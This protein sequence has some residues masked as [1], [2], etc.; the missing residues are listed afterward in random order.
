MSEE[1]GRQHDLGVWERLKQSWREADDL[2]VESW[3]EEMDAQ[4][5]RKEEQEAS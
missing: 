3:R 5:R 2:E 4:R 1:Q